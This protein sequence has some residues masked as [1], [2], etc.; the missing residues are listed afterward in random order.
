VRTISSFTMERTMEQRFVDVTDS[1]VKAAVPKVLAVSPSGVAMGDL[2]FYVVVN[3][4]NAVNLRAQ[5]MLMGA[6][7]GYSQGSL[8]LAFALMFWCVPPSSCWTPIELN[9]HVPHAPIREVA[10]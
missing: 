6:I 5:G 4:L 3:L 1:Y 9:T 8:F 7:Q 2:H 10:L